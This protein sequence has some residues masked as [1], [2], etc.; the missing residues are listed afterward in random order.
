LR[1]EKDEEVLKKERLVKREEVKDMIA[2]LV[3]VELNSGLDFAVSSIKSARVS[4]CSGVCKKR[5]CFRG[6]GQL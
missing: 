2:F 4:A 3:Q 1:R 6:R 5:G